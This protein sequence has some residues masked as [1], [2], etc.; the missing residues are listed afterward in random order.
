MTLLLFWNGGGPVYSVSAAAGGPMESLSGVIGSAASW[1]EFLGSS[2]TINGVF[3]AE[4]SMPMIAPSL[5]QAEW[6]DTGSFGA[7]AGLPFEWGNA[8]KADQVMVDE[9]LLAAGSVSGGPVLWA[10]TMQFGSVVL[11]TEWIT[12]SQRD[13][14]WPVECGIGVGAPGS[15][16]SESLSGIKFIPAVQIEW[17]GVI[18]QGGAASVPLE[19]L[20]GALRP[21]AVVAESLGGAVGPVSPQAEWRGGV[22]GSGSVPLES[23]GNLASGQQQIEWLTQVPAGMARAEALAGASGGAYPN[24]EWFANLQ[25]GPAAPVESLRGIGNTMA[26]PIED[27]AGIYGSPPPQGEW[28][29]R[30]TYAALGQSE[31]LA[32]VPASSSVAPAEYTITASRFQA[33]AEIE[34]GIGVGPSSAACA[35]AFSAT[36]LP[37]V[38]GYYVTVA[39]PNRS[40]GATQFS[41]YLSPAP[42][43]RVN[44]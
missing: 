38:S 40:A 10:S 25:A 36:P 6:T 44:T 26:A 8:L 39:A 34:F 15:V 35:I 31:N 32:S 29:G 30:F 24:A 37:T 12:T 18:A 16:G 1:P 4:S 17:G 43:S 20:I 23:T 2:I 19:A 42:L 22:L 21:L 9:Q 41:R 33:V 11:Q 5:L 27:L 13:H 7:D 28:F 14:V 3:A